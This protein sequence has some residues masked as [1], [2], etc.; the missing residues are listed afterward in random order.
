LER[1]LRNGAWARLPRESK[2]LLYVASR[3]VSRVRSPALREALSNIFLQVE[4]AVARGRALLAAAAHLL[5]RGLNPLDK[6]ME[7][8]VILGISIINHPLL[9]PG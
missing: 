8:L 1:A 9:S 3:M 2:A 5:S 4:L 7:A 6:P